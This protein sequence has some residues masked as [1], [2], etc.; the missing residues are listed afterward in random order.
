MMP[1]SKLIEKFKDCPFYDLS[2]QED[3]NQFRTIQMD[4]LLLFFCISLNYRH[5]QIKGRTYASFYAMF[6]FQHKYDYILA[7]GIDCQ[8]LF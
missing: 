8:L 5:N 4:L 2:A 1:V 6:S 3:V 7:S